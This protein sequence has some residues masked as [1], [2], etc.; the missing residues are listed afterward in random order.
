MIQKILV[1]VD[2]SEGSLNALESAIIIASNNNALLQILHITDIMPGMEAPYSIKKAKLICDAMAGNILIDHGIK[3]EI[4]FAEGIVGHVIAKIV[5][6][7]KTD[8]VIM[9]SHGL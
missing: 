6:E 7:N 4:I 9:G 1:P 2:F 5:F 8:L 3:A